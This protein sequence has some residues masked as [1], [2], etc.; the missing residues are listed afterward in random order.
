MK[1]FSIRYDARQ[2]KLDE[3]F[4]KSLVSGAKQGYQS[5]LKS[6]DE[7]SVMGDQMKQYASAVAPYISKAKSMADHFS[8]KTG[9]SMPLATALI[10]AGIFGGGS[11]IPFAAFVYFS[12]KPI[13]NV[14]NK[15]F[16][17]A[18]GAGEKVAGALRG[19]PSPQ[20]QP[21]NFSF[22][23]WLM[24]QEKEGWGD[25]LGRNIGHAAGSVAGSLVG[26]G[27]KVVKAMKSGLNNIY[28]YVSKNPKEVARAVFLIGI[29]AATGGMLGS[30]SHKIKDMVVQKIG[31]VM[32]NV[33]AAEVEWLRNNVVL[34]QSTDGNT[35]GHHGD[36]VLGKE[37]EFDTSRYWSKVGDDTPVGQA[38][39]AAGIE[40][41]VD[42]NNDD[43]G[44]II[45][46]PINVKSVDTGASHSVRGAG[47][48]G[49]TGQ[50]T[51]I[52]TRA[53]ASHFDPEND[54]FKVGQFMAGH[55]TTGTS[56]PGTPQDAMQQAYRDIAKSIHKGEPTLMQKL[57]PQQGGSET[58][59]TL[60][61]LAPNR[62]V[63]QQ[64]Y[65]QGAAD[66]IK[67]RLATTD[68]MTAT[69][70]AAGAAAGA[71][72]SRKSPA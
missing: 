36:V 69:G 2:Q 24:E 30:L 12:K 33:P 34:D 39:K 5:A 44:K 62:R 51:D 37:G 17:A 18:W 1:H 22:K 38:L 11:A 67:S 72:T 58:L 3:A 57:F 29:G 61:G 48:L 42:P 35:V 66:E 41:I 26:I 9:I 70:A 71:Q 68:T 63:M 16:D 8:K 13:M 40:P 19:S 60:K 65:G 15:A 55:E 14:A 59:D 45:N 23:E 7:P 28:Q 47:P 56:A 52:G 25:Y 4:V 20:L 50:M 21:E 27:G 54:G 53:H 6:G 32:Q 43:I 64:L 46:V 31:D 10:A 49:D